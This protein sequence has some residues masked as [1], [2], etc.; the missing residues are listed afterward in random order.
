[1]S[2]LRCKNTGTEFIHYKNDL[3]LEKE[4]NKFD[5]IICHIL[6]DDHP[7]QI[8]SFMELFLKSWNTKWQ[9]LKSVWIALSN[10]GINDS[11]MKIDNLPQY[12]E[13][14]QFLH[15]MKTL[16]QLIKTIRVSN[17]NKTKMTFVTANSLK[18]M[19]EKG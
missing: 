10:F 2:E 12:F 13:K 4:L 14:I 9:K 18:S 16:S 5:K 7:S 19:K 17:P 8:D 6:Y 15:P 1:M 11:K 3:E